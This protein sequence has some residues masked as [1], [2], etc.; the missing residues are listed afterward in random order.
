MPNAFADFYRSPAWIRTRAAVI[1]KR[2]G[3]CERCA[4]RG[5]IRAGDTVHHIK[6]LTA[7]N[8]NDPAVTLNDKNLMLLCRDCHAEIHRNEKRYTIDKVTGRVEMQDD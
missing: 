3:L 5:I 8:I 6:H 2:G 1:S 7:Q 4:Q